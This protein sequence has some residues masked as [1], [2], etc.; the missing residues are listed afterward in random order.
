LPLFECNLD[1]NHPIPV[2]SHQRKDCLYLSPAKRFPALVASLAILATLS[3]GGSATASSFSTGLLDVDAFRSSETV[4]FERAKAAGAK[5]VKNNLYWSTTVSGAESATRPGT[6]ETPFNATDPSSPYYD[7]TVWDRLVR[8]AASNNLT[9]ILSVTNSPRWARSGCKDSVVCSPK[10][11]DFADFAT[12]AA[13]RYSGTFDPGDGQGTLPRVKHWQAWVEPNLSLF[14][15][16][17]FKKN[18]A[19]AS[20]SSYRKLLNVFYRAVH[21]VRGSNVVMAAGLA[22]NAVPGRAIAPLDFTRRMLCM[23]GNFRKPRP[24]RGCRARTKADVW[25]VHPYTTGAPTHFPRKPDNMSVAALPRMVKLL[26]VARKTKR[27]RGNGRSTPLWATEF[28]WDSNRPDPGG[29]RWNLQTR[30]VAQAMYIMFRS[31]V[32]TLIWFGLRDEFRDGSRPFSET[33]ESGLYL[34]GKT[35]AEDKPKKVLKAFRYPFVAIK[36]RSGFRFWGRTPDGSSRNS[37]RP[38][39]RILARKRGG[40]SFAK[41][42]T[43]RANANGI[44]A[45]NVRRRGFTRRGAVRSKIVGGPTS[46]PFG[47]NKTRDFFQPPFG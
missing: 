40:G 2:S 26:R 14:Y 42:A 38:K 11:N 39:V 23:K 30:W 21:S 46:V 28:S 9:P 25:A 4:P 5:Y 10:P 31:N 22:P 19:P 6:A 45:G 16:P 13:K 35:L 43:V 37:G 3:V 1:R 7:W 47:L 15:R 24:K 27:L 20:P 29:L 41:V 18:G 32:R 17:V 36:T 8:N 12:A 34:R 33:F 44:F